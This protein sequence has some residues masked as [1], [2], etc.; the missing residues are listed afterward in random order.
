MVSNSP[1][2]QPVWEVR[3]FLEAD[4]KP[5]WLGIWH[6]LWLSA[7][8]LPYM[9]TESKFCALITV[10]L[11]APVV[12]DNYR[13]IYKRFG[14]WLLTLRTLAV[15]RLTASAW[16]K[17]S[18]S[19]REKYGHILG[20]HI[21]WRHKAQALQGWA[22]E[23]WIFCIFTTLISAIRPVAYSHWTTLIATKVPQLLISIP[24][25]FPIQGNWPCS[26]LSA[27]VCPLHVAYCLVL[28]G[29]Y[30][31]QVVSVWWPLRISTTEIKSSE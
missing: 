21:L 1:G 22:A 23:W 24:R 25:I 20:T 31:Y 14:Q 9:N 29:K 12:H 6:S 17:W 19:V 4:S 13:P 27:S 5:N 16:Q 18:L 11:L 26:S 10:P 30:A 15:R 8:K 3:V 7:R 2:W 28:W